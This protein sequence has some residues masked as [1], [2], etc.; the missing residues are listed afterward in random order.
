MLKIF[1]GHSP[2]VQC[3]L[4]ALIQSCTQTKCIYCFSPD[5]FTLLHLWLIY[6]KPYCVTCKVGSVYLSR[7]INLHYY[8]SKSKSN[9]FYCAFQFTTC[10]VDKFCKQL[11]LL[12]ALTGHWNV[13]RLLLRKERK[14]WELLRNLI[15]W[16]V[17]CGRT[18]Q[19]RW[20]D[21]AAESRDVIMY[22]RAKDAP[23]P[24]VDI[25]GRVSH[26]EMRRNSRS[27]FERR[28][29]LGVKYSLVRYGH[30]GQPVSW[31]EPSLLVSVL[32]H[33]EAAD[34]NSRPLVL[35]LSFFF[36]PIT[37]ASLY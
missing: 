32:L 6:P 33:F 14:W 4:G 25:Y 36:C 18:D 12:V 13:G 22:P 9:G 7:F 30:N 31:L 26:N 5:L 35:Y 17:S 3:D 8:C 28:Q 2:P 20:C 34:I 24:L 37:K 23:W 11:P 27:W 16:L 15:G 19:W 21:K 1:R 29:Q 10:F